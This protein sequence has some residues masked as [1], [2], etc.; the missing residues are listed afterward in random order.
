ML[1]DY[2]LSIPIFS[3]VRKKIEKIFWDI[4]IIGNRRKIGNISK[5]TKE[6][7]IFTNL[8]SNDIFRLFPIISIS[9]KFFSFFF[10]HTGKNR[11]RRK[12][13]LLP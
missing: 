3:S 9:Q 7:E 2:F 4:E 13:N 5:F 1:T 12:S 6:L 8:M 11:N 10:P